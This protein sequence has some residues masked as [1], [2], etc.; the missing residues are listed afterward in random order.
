MNQGLGFDVE[1]PRSAMSSFDD[2]RRPSEGSAYSGATKLTTSTS[3]L[4]TMGISTPI[5]HSDMNVPQP[6]VVEASVDSVEYPKPRDLRDSSDFSLRFVDEGDVGDK[7]AS[8]LL[9]AVS[10]HTINGEWDIY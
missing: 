10:V 7:S 2:P 4:D 8:S 3:G 9:T 6:A 1:Q 5:T